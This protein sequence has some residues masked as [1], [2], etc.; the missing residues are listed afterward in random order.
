[1]GTI[2]A[3]ILLPTAS[4]LLIIGIAWPLALTVM[5]GA[6]LARAGSSG[7]KLPRNRNLSGRA[8]A[9][10]DHSADDQKLVALNA[11]MDKA[12][13]GFGSS[14][15]ASKDSAAAGALLPSHYPAPT[16]LRPRRRLKKKSNTST[17]A[18]SIPSS[19]ART[20]K[21]EI[22]LSTARL[23]LQDDPSRSTHGPSHRAAFDRGR[24]RG[25]RLLRADYCF[26]PP[27]SLLA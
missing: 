8:K 15:A 14:G 22:A 11:Q 16:P 23:I 12:L 25:V 7:Y 10:K 20:K 24:K 27:G 17:A 3:T 4:G 5:Q 9:P 2:R 21:N 6:G 19:A 18:S 26:G 1:M 13:A